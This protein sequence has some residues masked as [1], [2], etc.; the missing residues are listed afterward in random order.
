MS[1]GRLQRNKNGA[2]VVLRNRTNRDLVMHFLSA[3]SILIEFLIDFSAKLYSLTL[4]YHLLC[5]TR[6]GAAAPAETPILAGHSCDALRKTQQYNHGTTLHESLHT[7]EALQNMLKQSKETYCTTNTMKRQLQSNMR[8]PATTCLLLACI[9]GLV[10][11]DSSFAD[12]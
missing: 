9:L 1:S 4:Q 3:Q 2:R 7:T 10:Q 11:G 12:H 5:T 6:R 8:I